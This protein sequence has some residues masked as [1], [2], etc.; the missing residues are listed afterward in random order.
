MKKFSLPKKEKEERICEQL[1]Q[2]VSFR[3][4]AADQHVSFSEIK[5]IKNKYFETD[6]DSAQNSK[7][8]LALKLMEEEKMSLDIAI[9]LNLSADEVQGFRQEYLTLKDEDDLLGIYRRIGGK[10]ESFL[11]LYEMMNEEDLS[12]EEAVWTLQDHGS[13]KNIDKKFTH[14]TKNLRS[15][16]EDLEQ[17]GKQREVLAGEV[18]RA[19]DEVD[20]LELRKQGLTTEIDKLLVRKQEIGSIMQAMLGV[21]DRDLQ[22]S[23]NA[24]EQSDGRLDLE[25]IGQTR[26]RPEDGLRQDT[27][28]SEKELN[29]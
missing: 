4:I 29:D 27:D 3:N 28:K 2:G 10:I 18:Q 22:N 1:R 25:W 11:K 12:A 19:S 5:R 20:Q 13:F 6:D 16:M 26:R 24:S 9:E 21:I 14:L 23:E 7:R 8:S 17:L 15:L